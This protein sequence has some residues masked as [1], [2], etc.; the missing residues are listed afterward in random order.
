MIRI[1][2]DR[3]RDALDPGRSGNTKKCELKVDIA[4]L[5]C[6]VSFYMVQPCC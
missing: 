3:G 4:Y 6:K 5:A 2:K 1:S